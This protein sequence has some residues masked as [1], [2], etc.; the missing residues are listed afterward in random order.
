M[1]DLR[2]EMRDGFGLAAIMALKGVDAGAIGRALG[3]DAPRSP[4]FSTGG[5]MRLIGTG[6]GTWL[7]YADDAPPFW[8]DRLRDRLS[9]LASVSDQSSGYVIQRLAGGD[10]RTL[11]QRGASI[12]FHPDAFGPGAVAST[13]I[14]HIGAIVWQLDDGPTYDVATFRSFAG[15]FRDWL[16]EAART[17]AQASAR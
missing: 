4:I 17:L 11:L 14:A 3:L 10:A 6:I 12:D 16:D 5:G 9:G 8:A 2:I 15:S 7:A 1:A 13:V